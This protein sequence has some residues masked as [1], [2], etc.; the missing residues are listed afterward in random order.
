MRGAWIEISAK[1]AVSRVWQRVA[2]LAGAWIEIDGR[3]K[4]HGLLAQSPPSRGR[5][6]KCLQHHLER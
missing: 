2:P 6:L 4:R 1:L 5:G 3:G